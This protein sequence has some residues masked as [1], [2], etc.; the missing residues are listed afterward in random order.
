MAVLN[1]E[2]AF[3]IIDFEHRDRR[4]VA[5]MEALMDKTRQLSIVVFARGEQWGAA[6]RQLKTACDKFA[7]GVL[8]STK[9]EGRN[10]FFIVRTLLERLA[11]LGAA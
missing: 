2:R 4:R 5:E 11:L 8:T 7:A 10:T 6:D 1:P 9:G 3:L